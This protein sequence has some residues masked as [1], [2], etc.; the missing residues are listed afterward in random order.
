MS[1]FKILTNFHKEKSF[2]KHEKKPK[3]Q[4]TMF[5]EGKT[6]GKAE[7]STVV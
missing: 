2:S 5:E 7:L 4:R 6:K 1:I 3:E